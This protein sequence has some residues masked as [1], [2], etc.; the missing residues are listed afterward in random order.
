MDITVQ[1]QYREICQTTCSRI[2][3]I[4]YGVLRRLH[5]LD[6]RQKASGASARQDVQLQPDLRQRVLEVCGSSTTTERLKPKKFL[7][8][9]LTGG[10]ADLNFKYSEDLICLVRKAFRPILL[11]Q[12]AYCFS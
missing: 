5:S 10:V 12:S 7:S 8:V 2:R 11:G 1:S 3:L 4:D 6:K 9:A